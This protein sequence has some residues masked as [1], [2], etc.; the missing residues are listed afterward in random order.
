MKPCLEL[1]SFLQNGIPE[2]IP[3]AF[4]QLSPENIVRIDDNGG[5][6]YAAPNN[7]DTEFVT[8]V[9]TIYD[10]RELSLKRRHDAEELD[11]P[12]TLGSQD[13]MMT[14]RAPKY[15]RMFGDE[16]RE[17]GLYLPPMYLEFRLRLLH[18]SSLFLP[19]CS[20]I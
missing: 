15:P 17:L 19:F 2:D 4:Q 5:L 1:K 9:A 18:S 11:E 13:D 12:G 8:L 10:P 14:G 7:V 16:N 20:S 6:F 3:A